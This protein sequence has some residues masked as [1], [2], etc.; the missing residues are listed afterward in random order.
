MKKDIDMKKMIILILVGVFSFWVLNNLGIIRGIFSTIFNVLLPFILG[1]AIAFI[2]NIPM[3]KIESI[4]KKKIKNKDSLVRML[5]ITLSLLL[6]IVVLLFVALLLIPELVENI[7]MLINSI[8]GLIDKIR[9]FV[10]DLVD[11]YPDIQ[12]QIEE[13]FSGQGNVTDIVSNVLNYFVNGAVGFVSSLISGFVTIFTAT[14]F[15]IYMLSQKE[16][17]IRGSKKVIHAIINKKKADRVI[18]IGNMANNIFSK[19]LSGQCLEAIVLGCLMFIAFSLFRF[20]YALLISVLTAVTAL[21]PIFGAFIAAAIGFVLIALIN[22]LQAIIFIIV[23]LVVQQIEGNFIY[24]RVVGKSVGLS[25]MW[26]LLAVTAGGSLFGVVGMLIGLPLASVIY[27]IVKDIINK[28]IKEK[29]IK[30]N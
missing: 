6:F 8:P 25:P 4:L 11:K 23:F 18:E 16:Y 28:K 12:S 30:L 20:P 24:P 5:S 10:V 19:F 21:I 7:K 3:R 13:L 2:L 15:S 29:E 22:P 14:I 1:G 9:V 17:L 27:A 26:T